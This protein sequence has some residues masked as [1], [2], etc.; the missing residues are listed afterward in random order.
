M[1]DMTGPEAL[2]T[3][4]FMSIKES[5]QVNKVSKFEEMNEQNR[6]KQ[7]GS[8]NSSGQNSIISTITRPLLNYPD[9]LKIKQ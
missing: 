5:E 9:Q 2:M 3:T 1:Q 7:L 4:E 8:I 6:F